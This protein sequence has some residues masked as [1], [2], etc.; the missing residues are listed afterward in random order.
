MFLEILKNR[1]ENTCARVSFLIKL[2]AF[3]DHIGATVSKKK[4]KNKNKNKSK[5]KKK[6]NKNKNE[7]NDQTCT[8]I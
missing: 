6:I 8:H 5:K 4:K 2:K 3:P 1:Q 7:T